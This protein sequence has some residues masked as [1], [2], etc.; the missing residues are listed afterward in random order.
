M[1]HRRSSNPRPSPPGSGAR[2]GPPGAD[3]ARRPDLA[4]KMIVA[5]DESFFGGQMANTQLTSLR[6]DEEK[7]YRSAPGA[8]PYYLC[9]GADLRTAGHRPGVYWRSARGRLPQ[10]IIGPLSPR[11]DFLTSAV[12]LAEHLMRLESASA[13]AFRLLRALAQ[14]YPGG[15]DGFGPADPAKVIARGGGGAGRA[16]GEGSDGQAGGGG[17]RAARSRFLQAGRAALRFRGQD[18]EVGVNPSRRPPGAHPGPGAATRAASRAL[19][20]NPACDRRAGH[21]RRGG[22]RQAAADVAA[23][24]RRPVGPVAVRDPGATS[25]SPTW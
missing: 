24:L 14:N 23:A 4:A 22:D 16:S 13:G 2:T 15:G 6:R 19:A 5:V 7:S 10:R 9:A 17:A 25:S 12:R 18:G 20:A 8:R 1:G 11:T 3:P 21:P